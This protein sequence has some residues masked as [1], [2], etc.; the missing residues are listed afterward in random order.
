MKPKGAAEEFKEKESE[1]RDIIITYLASKNM[2]FLKDPVSR[3]IIKKELL[4]RINKKLEN[5]EI[6]EIYIPNFIIQ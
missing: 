5:S 3:N 1:I 2:E 6:T 4:S